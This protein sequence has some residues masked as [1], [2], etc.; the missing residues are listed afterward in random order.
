MWD[1]SDVTVLGKFYKLLDLG[2]YDSKVAQFIPANGLAVPHQDRTIVDELH[3]IGMYI[4][5]YNSR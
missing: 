5:K 3:K 1:L 4:L 2:L